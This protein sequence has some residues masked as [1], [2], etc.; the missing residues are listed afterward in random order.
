MK[1]SEARDGT[2]KARE[3]KVLADYNK[4]QSAIQFEVKTGD[5]KFQIQVYGAIMPENVVALTED[6][7]KVEK[8]ESHRNETTYT[9][10][11]N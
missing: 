3:A 11:W 7:Y 5:G 8:N 1:A 6:G 4:V 9:V 2:N 10:S